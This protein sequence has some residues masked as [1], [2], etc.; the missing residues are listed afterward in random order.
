MTSEYSRAVETIRWT[1]GLRA[2]SPAFS[3]SSAPATKGTRK[4][5]TR[6]HPTQRRRLI[7]SLQLQRIVK[8]QD[9]PGPTGEGS[10]A[11][12]WDTI[13]LH[14][15]DRVQTVDSPAGPGRR[16]AGVGV[17][18]EFDRDGAGWI[19]TRRS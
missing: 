17:G 5:A 11:L 12:R 7:G 2:F 18:T 15:G 6:A 9:R 8:Q 13:L 3:F 16:G 10:A 19:N 1:S 14:R 4:P